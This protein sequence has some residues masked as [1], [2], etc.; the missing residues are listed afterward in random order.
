VGG[1]FH[2]AGAGNAIRGAGRTTGSASA[3][4]KTGSSSGS[5]SGPFNPS[6][7]AG[8]QPAAAK[9]QHRVG[10]QTSADGHPLRTTKEP[11]GG[12]PGLEELNPANAPPWLR[13]FLYVLLGASI[14][15]LVGLLAPKSVRRRFL[16]KFAPKADSA[17]IVAGAPPLPVR[18]IVRRFWPFARPYRGSLLLMLLLVPVAPVIAATSVLVFKYLV[19]HVL[20]PHDFG[21]FPWVAAAYV[22]LTLVGGIAS[23]LDD[24]LSTLIGERFI[25]DLRT[26]VFRHVQ[27]LSLDFFERRRLGDVMSRL[28]SDVESIEDLMLSGVASAIGYL[29]RIAIFAGLLFYLRWDLAVLSLAVAPIFLVAGRRFARLRRAAARE[30]RRR[31]GAMS[32]VVEES[33]SNVQLVQ[34]YNRQS[35]EV[36]RFRREG[37]G[38]LV[39]ELASTRLKAVYGPLVELVELAGALLIVGVGTWELARGWLTLGALLAFLALLTQL[40]R[41]VRGLGR[42]DHGISSAVAASERI[43]ELLDQQTAVVEP[44]GARA[45]GRARGAIEFDDVTFRYPDAHADVLNDVSFAVEPGELLAI[46][47]PSGAAKSTLAKLLLRFYDPTRGAVLLDGTDLRQLTLESLR[48]QIAVVFQETL[49]FDASIADN[50]AY[51]RHSATLEE[52]AAA[53]DAAALTPF[54]ATLPDGL[55][56]PIGQKGRRLSGG[57]RQRIAIARAFL[58]NAPVLLLDEPTTGLDAES[59]AQVVEPLRRLADGRTT[60]VISHDL[61]LA[62]QASHILVVDA[63]RIVEFGTHAELVSH[64]GLYRWLYELRGGEHEPAVTDREPMAPA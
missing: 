64:D 31:S 29:L 51:G 57:Q 13:P 56:T 46:V 50:I 6:A 8:L 49:V 7:L 23:F 16:R 58:R 28:T 32:S 61:A 36:A 24:Y 59:A 42:L 63:G 35:T 19:D 5:A 11:S 54:I 20:V 60:I 62:R 37:Q 4:G 43:I 9:T 30:I 38:S 40:Y 12:I 22:G 34:A 55:H 41:P 52:I 10:N 15:L 2:S 47:G 21:P 27:D 48:E 39:A 44:D 45:I 25:L 3:H 14:A 18:T 26:H 33:F 17:G 53:A 1:T